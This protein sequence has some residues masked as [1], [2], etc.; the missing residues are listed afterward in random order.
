MDEIRFTLIRH[1]NYN[2]DLG[3]PISSTEYIRTYFTGLEIAE[4]FGRVDAIYSSYAARAE[5]TAKVLG[6]ALNCEE[7]ETNFSLDENAS[8]EELESFF[9]KI[10]KVAQEK[11]QKHLLF[12]MHAPCLFE[13]FGCDFRNLW[14]V[15]VD[16]SKSV[17][18]RRLNSNEWHYPSNLE[19]QCPELSSV[20]KGMLI[21]VQPKADV[22]LREVKA[23]HQLCDFSAIK[24]IIKSWKKLF[25]EIGGI[26]DLSDESDW[27]EI[28]LHPQ[29]RRLD[30]LKCVWQC[31][32]K[33]VPF[34][35][36]QIEQI[37]LFGGTYTQAK[38]LL[39]VGANEFQPLFSS[40]KNEVAFCGYVQNCIETEIYEANVIVG[41]GYAQMM[42][43]VNPL[44]CVNGVVCSFSFRTSLS[45]VLAEVKERYGKN[46]SDDLPF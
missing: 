4:K 38:L 44:L 19:Q 1:A 23:F 35:K 41:E 43:G 24:E 30:I 37:G 22:F 29:A 16:S 12:V 8:V 46:C 15:N 33:C 18:G 25:L 3:L 2:G 5:T 27:I 32:E 20:M 9:N 45:P 10:E 31:V 28:L 39:L 17:S 7:T 21:D 26:S 34:S 36:Q 11:Q 13:L 40:R 42:N 6:V 14:Y